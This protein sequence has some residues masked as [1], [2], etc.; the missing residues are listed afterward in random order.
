MVTLW[1]FVELVKRERDNGQQMWALPD[2][3]LICWSTRPRGKNGSPSRFNFQLGS[4][5]NQFLPSF[6]FGGEQFHDFIIKD[7]QIRPVSYSIWIIWETS[8]RSRHTIIQ[9]FLEVT[10]CFARPSNKNNYSLNQQISAHVCIICNHHVKGKESQLKF[11]AHNH[12]LYIIQWLF[13][14][15]L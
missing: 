1:S 2:A 13:P 9:L 3:S 11:I 12:S 14:I 10:S 8:K 15:E 4:L 5:Q 7:N 6:L